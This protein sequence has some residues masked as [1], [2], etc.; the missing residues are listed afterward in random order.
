MAKWSHSFQV[1]YQKDDADKSGRSLNRT[2]ADNH[3]IL[4]LQVYYQNVRGL[5]TKIS[6]VYSSV[7]SDDYDIIDF[8]ETWLTESFHD[9]DIFVKTYSAEKR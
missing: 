7:L 6:E 5:R 2:S 1:F 9:A 3:K 4:Q 8:T